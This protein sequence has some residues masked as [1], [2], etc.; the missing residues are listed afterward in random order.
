MPDYL[1][2]PGSFRDRNGRVFY[3]QGKTFR[4][5]SDTA[6]THWKMLLG[7]EFFSRKMNAGKIIAT[8]QADS[9]AINSD[10]DDA[11]AAHLI[12]QTIPFISY[13]YEW[14]FS[15]LK[16]AALLHLELLLDALEEN[17]ILKDSSAYN[18]QW[19][20][21]NPVFIDI[22]S[23]E[24]LPAGEPWV[25]Y[26]QFCQLFLYPLL[27]QAYK[28][29]D[30]HSFLRGNIEGI[31]PVQMN[32]LMSLRDTFRPGVLTNIRLQ[33]K[34][35]NQFGKTAKNV[36]KELKSAGFNKD[37]ITANVKR[38]RKLVTTLRWG[39]SESQWSAYTETHSYTDS[40]QGRKA[41]FIENIAATKN[42]TLVWDI[43]CNTGKFS[44]IAASHA[45]YV[46][47]MDAD[48][49]CID[50]LYRA[51]QDEDLKNILPLYMN[52]ADPSPDLGWRG[53]ERK[54]L[55]MR[56]TPDLI[57]C[58]ALIHHAVI[59]AN[60]P[61]QDFVDW[62]A[63]L[64]SSIIIEFVSKDDVMVQTL[65]RNKEDQYDDYTPEHFEKVLARSFDVRRTEKLGSGT[66]QLYFATPK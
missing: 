32:N 19:T 25:G 42:Y 11:W 31:D 1:Y 46:V 16:D 45:D 60:I 65:L 34:L 9:I 23:F 21:V 66:R 4:S 30:F 37:L 56:G 50:H 63:S 28:D 8:R 18:I 2:E 14:S 61:V 52:L 44:R 59:S 17:M 7:T 49:L 47:A 10:S 54:S 64:D 36:K 48:H 24:A 58:L 5:L 27:L 22:P 20:G 29:V 51:L 13:P 26:R 3:A 57:L 55:T 6:Y 12:H 41:A 40:D 62:L 39:A 53:L 43:G 35:Q 15:M 38:I 33:A